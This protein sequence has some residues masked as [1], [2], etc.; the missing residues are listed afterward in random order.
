MSATNFGARDLADLEDGV[1]VLYETTHGHHGVAHQHVG[2]DGRGVQLL[3]RRLDSRHDEEVF[4][5]TIHSGR[6]LKDSREKLAGLL[7]ERSLMVEQRLDVATDRGQW[8]TQLVRDVGNEVALCAFHL[9]DA[10]NVVQHGDR[11]ATGHR[12]DG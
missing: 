8:R 2:G 3:L 5:Q 10:G 4:G 11:A 12:R 6:V 9:F 7:A 1:C